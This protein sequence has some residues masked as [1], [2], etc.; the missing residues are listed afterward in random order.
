MG[1]IA[2][3]FRRHLRLDV[4]L[5]GGRCDGLEVNAAIR[6]PGWPLSQRNWVN[7]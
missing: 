6:F 2:L 7:Q 3:W 1:E 5:S 4:D